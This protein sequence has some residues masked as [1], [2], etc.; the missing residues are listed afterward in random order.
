MSTIVA[1]SADP[2]Y[3]LSLGDASP[4]DRD[5]PVVLDAIVDTA[6]G[7]TIDP[8]GGVKNGRLRRLLCRSSC[9]ARIAARR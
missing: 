2:I 9:P 4:R 7:E 3:R 1:A 6:N 8:I 5:V